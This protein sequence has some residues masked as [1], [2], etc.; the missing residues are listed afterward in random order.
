MIKYYALTDRQ[1]QIISTE[2]FFPGTSVNTIVNTAIVTAS[3]SLEELTKVLYK[4]ISSIDTMRVRITEQNGK[5]VQYFS[6]EKPA[7]IVHKSFIS[8]DKSYASY[9]TQRAEQCLFEF[10]KPLYCFEI[11]TRPNGKLELVASFH[12]VI[13]DAWSCA[14]VLTSAICEVF[15]G[16]EPNVS[17]FEQKLA[18][19]SA[20]A[21]NKIIARYVRDRIYWQT[22]F[23]DY[24]GNTKHVV[25]PETNLRCER[26]HYD[27]S[28]E[29][30]NGL[31]EFCKKI[32]I[33]LPEILLGLVLLIKAYKNGENFETIAFASLGRRGKAERNCFG[34]FVNILP[35]LIPIERKQRIADYIS[36]VK[37]EEYDLLYHASYS[38]PDLIEDL[39]RKGNE[40]GNLMD[41]SFS[42]QNAK[43]DSNVEDLFG[44]VQWI[45]GKHQTIPIS[46]HISDREDDGVMKVDYDYIKSIYRQEEVEWFHNELILL[47]RQLIMCEEPEQITIEQLTMVNDV[48]KNLILETFQGAQGEL[49]NQNIVTLLEENCS[50]Y[51]KACALKSET[52]CYTY[53]ELK[54]LTDR[55]AFNLIMHGVQCGDHVAIMAKR[56]LESILCICGIIKAGAAYVPIDPAYPVHR[57][58]QVLDN[59]QP[60]LFLLSQTDEL[61]VN[62]T[63][64]CTLQELFSQNAEFDIERIYANQ[65]AINLESEAYIIFTSGTTG[66]PKGVVVRH[67]EIVALVKEAD[68]VPLDSKVRI[69]QTGSLAFDAATF[70]IWGA[71]LNGGML[72]LADKRV[73][74]C[75]DSLKM[76][77][78][79][80]KIN[81][82]FI[83]TALFNEMV[84]S[85]VSVFDPLSYL[86]FGGEKTSEKFVDLLMDHPGSPNVHNVYGP[87]ETTTFATFY[88]I[89][90]Q[91]V[92]DQ[93]PIGHAIK[94]MTTYVLQDTMLC[95]IGVPGELC[96]GGIGVV[97]G[98]LNNDDLTT[99]RFIKNPYG[100]GLLYRT[101]DIVEWNAQG[102]LIYIGRNDT[103]VKIRGFRIELGEIETAINRHPAV[104]DSVIV[105][106]DKPSGEKYISAYIVLNEED[107][108][109]LND[110]RISLKNDF[111]EYM[112]PT[113]WM[114]IERIP[115]TNNG[116]VDKHSLPEITSQTGTEEYIA[117]RT[118]EEAV[119]CDVIAE[120]LGVERVGINDNFFEIGGD[121]IKSIRVSSTMKKH[122]YELSVQDLI[123]YQSPGNVCR[124][125]AVSILKQKYP[126][127][128][129]TGRFA[130]SPIQMMF[131]RKRMQKPDYFNQAVMLEANGVIDEQI[132]SKTMELLLIQHDILRSKFEGETQIID[133]VTD[134][135]SMLSHK[136]VFSCQYQEATEEMEKC[137]SEWQSELSLK[138]GKVIG[139][140]LI[141]CKD[142]A[143]LFLYAHHM[144]IDGVSWRILLEQLNDLYLSL[145]SGGTVKLPIKTMPYGYWVNML[146]NYAVSDKIQN[147]ANYWKEVS[148][149]IADNMESY[150][151]RLS[152][153]SGVGKVTFSLK[154]GELNQLFQHYRSLITIGEDELLMG[155]LGMA[156]QQW[157]EIINLCADLEKHGR[158]FSGEDLS[159]TI[160]WFT[161][162]YP[163]VCSIKSDFYSMLQ[164]VKQ[165]T[166]DIPSNGI[167]YGLLK[168][169]GDCKVE[170]NVVTPICFNYLGDASVPKESGQFF[171]YT[172]YSVGKMTADENELFNPLT[173]DVIKVKDEIICNLSYLKRF[174][175]VD[176]VEK[177]AECIQ[178]TFAAALADMNK[179]DE[180]SVTFVKEV[181]DDELLDKID[182][183]DLSLLNDLF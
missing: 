4:A 116:K 81:T 56:S 95:G 15:R 68:Y 76:C 183:Q 54:E 69:L 173:F 93:T 138:E 165:A 100:E 146:Q 155:V 101:G 119:L 30:V 18:A 35:L 134:H 163:F 8:D 49:L 37:K 151:M 66:T 128:E 176:D 110:I 122:G 156:L 92:Y 124:N 55:I 80:E 41:F 50:K 106:R 169:Y 5:I 159:A 52:T 88:P 73:M 170:N 149:K 46:I 32:N 1:N 85:D 157:K 135:G 178:K 82:M 58:Q 29:I 19:L 112:I 109:I 160:G 113:A 77:L 17:S 14:T 136:A 70:E 97:K 21:D 33:S 142:K 133:S 90:R 102:E 161:S 34:Y 99:K 6:D 137:C 59:V 40:I 143:L 152:S 118:V 28:R 121:S 103:Q 96:I 108:R 164:S 132:L 167:G 43:Y 130:L 166:L 44:K 115:L 62:G 153:D 63:N 84:E 36:M 107:D 78:A 25:T 150:E 9:L 72:F 120:T 141:L 83:T 2:L 174:Y 177:L 67:K 74:L 182:A 145:Q 23:E 31:N 60:K 172:S 179:R 57:V 22:K 89:S 20:G 94:F 105:V 51:P 131:V 140:G 48:E 26:L 71:I 64:T 65:T 13:A 154:T 24:S 129:V 144:V 168:Y 127:E 91:R 53:E 10:D 11:V 27:I 39:R 175:S 117:P 98:Y 12:H 86:L 79:Q 104:R 125:G 139:Y 147:Q 16:N 87:T 7:A 148:R 38:Y 75:A 45:P 180:E 162:K 111:P 42:Y 123:Q 181:V 3:I 61:E 158:D 114:K 47:I 126:Q 171:H